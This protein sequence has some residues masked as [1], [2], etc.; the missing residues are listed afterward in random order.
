MGEVN[1]SERRRKKRHVFSA[2][3]EVTDLSSGAKASTRA[4]D[5]SLQG[6]FLDSMNPFEVG[7]KIRLR[8]Q[9]GGAEL[10]CTAVVRDSQPGMGMG[11]A[12]TEM[13]EA[14][15]ALLERWIQK[16]NQPGVAADLTP[17]FSEK[18]K[19]DAKPETKETLALRLVNLLQKKGLLSTGEVSALLRDDI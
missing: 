16:L 1:A 7:S 17:S 18:S 19:K 3:T 10:T 2:T 12:F 8:I 6:C 5:L 11:V 15:N 4:A 9:W 14:R 13:D